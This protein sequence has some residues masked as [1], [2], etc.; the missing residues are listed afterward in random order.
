MFVVKLVKDSVNLAFIPVFKPHTHKSYILEHVRRLWRNQR[1]N[2]NPYI[3]KKNRQHDGQKKKGQ[4]DKQR[5]TK[6]T[7]KT[8]DRVTRTPLKI[9][10]EL[11]CYGKVSRSCSTIGTHRVLSF[12]HLWQFEHRW[13]EVYAIQNYKIKFVSDLRQAGFLRV[14][15]FPPP[16]KLT[17]TI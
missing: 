5:S 3:S 2:Q 17:V 16:I 8:K 6:H 13:S 4:Q 9:G 12:I 14:L 1:G 10:G 7:C 15:R 11:R